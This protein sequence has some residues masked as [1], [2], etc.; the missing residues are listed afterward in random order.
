MMAAEF[1]MSSAPPMAWNIRRNTSS[2]APAGPV[3][4][5]SDKR[6]APRVNQANPRLYILTRPKMSPMRPTVTTTAAE[7]SK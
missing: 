6:I 1:A 4:Q 2:S 5:T 3:L 7:T